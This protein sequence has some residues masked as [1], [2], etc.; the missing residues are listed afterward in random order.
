LKRWWHDLVLPL[1]LTALAIHVLALLAVFV[2]FIGVLVYVVVGPI[3]FV[4]MWV[5]WRLLKAR[6][7]AVCGATEQGLCSDCGSARLEAVPDRAVTYRCAACG[8]WF[9]K[10]GKDKARRIPA[11]RG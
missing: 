10:Y 6:D 7:R 3:T 1:S 9:A 5:L 11:G 2:P 4:A 8:S